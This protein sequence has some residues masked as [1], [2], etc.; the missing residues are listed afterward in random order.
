MN[1]TNNYTNNDTSNDNRV[2]WL[3]HA[4][5]R[6]PYGDGDDISESF[7]STYGDGDDAIDIS[8]TLMSVI[9]QDKFQ[10]SSVK[11]PYIH[12]K[13]TRIHAMVH[14]SHTEGIPSL[15]MRIRQIVDR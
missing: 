15:I 12:T 10:G 6:I 1:D 3:E 9:Q 5:R 7:M 13:A 11:L 14:P 4:Q 8:E 2:T